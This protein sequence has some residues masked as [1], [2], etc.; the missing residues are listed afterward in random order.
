[1]D[2]DWD[3]PEG[4]KISAFIF[5]GRRADT[6]PLVYEATNW[7][8]GVF[9]GAT[10]ASETTAAATGTV[11]VV[12]R[13]PMAMLPF[14][15][16]HMGEY[17]QHWLEMG[18]NIKNPPKVF[19]VN[20]FRKNKEGKFIWPGFGEN[21]RVLQWMTARVLGDKNLAD[22]G[23]ETPVGIMPRYRDLNW[24]G[25]NLDE[26]T[27]AEL[28]NLDTNKW[29]DEILHQ[30]DFFETLV[31]HLPPVFLEI[32]KKL[33]KDFSIKTASHNMQA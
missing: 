4:I 24:E 8:R 29:L 7:N 33:I 32:Q 10:T 11:G 1:M 26:A 30:V 2:K 27:F 21:M 16:Y 6:T 28:M 20:W 23:L 31:E 12:R 5:G 13:D 15:G 18:I 3:S 19:S 9:I 22:N 25:L 14:C 17:F